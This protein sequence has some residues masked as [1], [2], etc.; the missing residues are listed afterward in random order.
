MATG[1]G[2]NEPVLKGAFR[3]GFD[4]LIETELVCREE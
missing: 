2:W 1:S 4:S 3:Q